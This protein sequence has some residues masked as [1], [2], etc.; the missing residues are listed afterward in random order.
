MHGA[1]S[2]SAVPSGVQGVCPTGWHLPSDAEWSQLTDYVGSVPEYQCGGNSSYIAKA[3]ASTT[4]WHTDD[5]N[6]AVGN[7]QSLN[8]ASGFGA[9]PAG[10]WGYGFAYA[11]YDAYFWSSTGG[12]SSYAYSLGLLHDDYEVYSDYEEYK[13]D[14]C[15]V[16]CLRD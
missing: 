14:G 10:S 16:R 6:C 4:G 8:N 11:G 9:V 13:Y 12:S 15:S 1:A 5:W 3:L 2:S 7:D